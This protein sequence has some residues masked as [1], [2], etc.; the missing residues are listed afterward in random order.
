MTSEP[1]VLSLE[2][3]RAL[4]GDALVACGAAPSNAASV[5]RALV[6]AEA[7]GQIGHGLSRVPSYAAQLLSGKVDGRAV[8]AVVRAAP[9]VLRV[10]AGLGFAYP[11]FD[12]V[13]ETLPDVSRECGLALAAIVRSH[14]FG[15]AGAHCERLA[16]Q[17]LIAFVFGNTPKAMAPWGGR[18]P[19]LGTNPIAFAAPM[20]TDAPLV[21]DLALSR[22]ARGRVLA[23]EKA[24]TAIPEG[25]ALD[26]SGSPTTD[27]RAALEGTMIPIGE[28][29]G[30]ALALMVEVMSAALVGANFA[31]EASSFLDSAGPP[32]SVG[33]TVIAIDAERVSGGAITDRMGVLARV[34]EAEPGVRLP[35]SKRFALR[36]KA[37]REGLSVPP[38]LL[39]EIRALS[40][41]T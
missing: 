41:R 1:S 2:A 17:G 8:P 37:Q 12:R 16:E 20:P 18:M 35:G 32:P 9:A 30:A 19:L 15:Q 38:S 7:D 28:A 21:I 26:T 31:F 27:P 14:H 39:A 29:K 23:A 13:T 25:W 11:A 4:A 10:D 22:V 5:A 36:A 40:G 6:A 33:Q 3:A 24:G 34:F